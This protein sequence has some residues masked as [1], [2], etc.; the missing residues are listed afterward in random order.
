MI[1][2]KS[3]HFW[4][5]VS[6]LLALFFVIAF[7]YPLCILLKSAV[8]NPAGGYTL[9]NFRKFFQNDYYFQTILNSL[10][11][12]FGSMLVCLLIGIPFS[13][14]Y[15]FYDVKGKRLLL[16]LCVLSTMSAPFIG[17][18]SWIMLLGRNGII[19]NFLRLIHINIGSI[20]GFGGILITQA[21]KLFP[22][23]VIYMNGAF[24]ALDNSLLEA[25]EGLG[26]KGVKRLFTVTLPLT[27][28]TILAAA[29]L[30][31]M[32]AFADFGTP[33]LIGE[34]YRTFPVEIYNQF[35]GEVGTNRGL[36]CALSV[37]AIV[38]TAVIF[39]GQ[40][41]LT[42]KSSFSVSALHP[43]EQRKCG[44]CG[45]LLMNFYCYFLIF[46]SM[47]PNIYIVIMSFHNYKNSVI[48]EGW[49]LNNYIDA[50]RRLLG[51]SVKNT[52]IIG[53][54]GLA[55]IIVLS[56][57]IAYL[58]VRRGGVVNHA[59]D[60]ISM[61]PYIMPGTV[62]GIALIMAFNSKPLIL[63]GTMAIMI[64]AVVIRRLPYSV[65]STTATLSQ[66]SPNIDEAAVSLG[67]SKL[68]TFLTITVPMMKNGIISGGILSWVSIITEV[69]SALILYNNRTITLTM[70]VYSFILKGSDGV[71]MAFASVTTLF[72]I[73]SM[74][75][76]MR[77]SNED[78]LRL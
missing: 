54:V 48:Q 20:Y 45:K 47:L 27:F 64:L 31:F 57:I 14:F 60:T 21:T 41:Y 65:R 6:L 15:S 32:R 49:S 69:S 7:L 67:A 24:K 10:K 72:T 35:V 76:F 17:A 66:I 28:P 19:T 18:Y 74:L 46:V 71:A 56:V 40:K 5:V 44:L 55:I 26:V 50:S 70:S 3:S 4:S 34:G 13:Y 61:L 11:V 51:R 33:M 8:E 23:V 77:F 9:E 53:V 29:L 75:I 16:I 39:F 43:I 12:S 25:A 37:V 73:V 52:V 2:K 62:V 42:K 30:I 58:V 36:A 78:E 63:T 59:I 1:K 38:L 22:L 68:K